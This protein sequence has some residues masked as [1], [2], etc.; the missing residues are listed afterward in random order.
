MVQTGPIFSFFPL[1]PDLKKLNPTEGFKRV[2]SLKILFE[3]IK[4]S[5][6]IL[7]L[8]L[9]LYLVLRSI[10]PTLLGLAQSDYRIFPLVVLEE[11]IRVLRWCLVALLPIFLIDL[12]YV[13]RDFLKKMMMSRREVKDEYKQREG[14]PRIR[15]KIRELQ[16]EARKRSKSLRNVKDADVLITNPTRL[17][18]A[19]RYNREEM[20]APTIVAKGA[21]QLA[22]L[23]KGMALRHQVPVVENK[24]LARALF[25]KSVIDSQVPEEFYPPVARLLTWVYTQRA[26]RTQRA[27]KNQSQQSPVRL[28]DLATAKAPAMRTQHA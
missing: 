12:I 28:S 3:G 20:A 1:K 10:M 17:A 6:K 23:M 22:K 4:S 19:I 25:R 11:V 15:S 13:R 21:G 5:F 16:K 7:A 2:F 26:Q 18:I 9:T 8:A 14:D 24:K 27:A